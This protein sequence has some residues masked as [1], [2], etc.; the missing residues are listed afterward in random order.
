[1]KG[2]DVTKRLSKNIEI[3]NLLSEHLMKYPDLRFSQLMW[4][5]D[6]GEDH[7][8]EEPE[9]TLRRYKKWLGNSF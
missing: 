9:E 2:M 8:Y 5:L 1:M 6:N 4:C 7:F 3:L